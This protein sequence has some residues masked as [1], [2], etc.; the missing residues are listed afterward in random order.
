MRPELWL[1]RLASS[2]CSLGV[3][4]LQCEAPAFDED[5]DGGSE[6]ESAG[7]EDDWLEELGHEISPLITHP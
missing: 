2:S 5:T 3:I 6:H 1:G 7:E 4:H